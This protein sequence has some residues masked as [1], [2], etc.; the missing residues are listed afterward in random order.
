MKIGFLF[1]G[2]GSQSIGMG[3]DLY[4]KFE[5]YRNVYEK[6]K[7]ITGID[8][9]KI[10]FE[11]NENELNETK[12]TQICIL[13]MS[14][15]IL[16]LLKEYGV[17]ASIASGLSLGEYSALIYSNAISFEDGVKII[18]KRGE[19]MQNLAPKGEWLMAAI[20][21]LEE[22][23][24]Q[25]VCSKVKNGFVVPVNYNCIGQI[26]VSGDKQ[27]VEAAEIIAKQMGAK[28]VRVLK[29]SGPFHTEKLIKVSEA[30]ALELEKISFKNFNV[31]V[32]KNI[33]GTEYSENDNIKNIL[34]KHIISPVKFSKT[35][36][37]MLNK[38]I[39]TFIEIGP[40][41]TLS[42]FVKRMSDNKNINILNINN[43]ETLEKTINFI[44]EKGV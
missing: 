28:K 6:V 39:D 1:P 26:V 16:K 12:N 31:Q 7:R 18:Q 40:G 25:M 30:L 3:K 9:A 14:L 44:K 13:T 17:S 2:Q 38:G 5:S 24:V 34:A 22:N 4:E 11:G 37:N 36:E 43:V 8:V 35:L 15:A 32:I 10:T 19:Y 20:L 33:D 27:G 23:K 29:T 42:G 41:K 21:G